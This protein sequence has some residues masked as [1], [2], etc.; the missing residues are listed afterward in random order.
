MSKTLGVFGALVAGYVGFSAYKAYASN[1]AGSAPASAD[2]SNLDY[3]SANTNP[4]NPLAASQLPFFSSSAATPASSLILISPLQ[5]NFN[6]LGSQDIGR[7]NESVPGFNYGPLQQLEA[8]NAFFDALDHNQAVIYFLA[9]LDPENWQTWEGSREGLSQYAYDPA[10]G[11]V[12]NSDLSG[13]GETFNEEVTLFD[14]LGIAFSILS[15]TN[16]IGFAVSIASSVIKMGMRSAKPGFTINGVGKPSMQPNAEDL[17]GYSGGAESPFA[18]N[19]DGGRGSSGVE[20][21]TTGDSGGPSSP[22]APPPAPVYNVFDAFSGKQVDSTTI[23]PFVTMTL[24]GINNVV[25]V[26]GNSFSDLFGPTSNPNS[27]AIQD[28]IQRSG[29]ITNYLTT[30]D[31]LDI[32]YAPGEV[33]GFTGD[34]STPNLDTPNGALAALRSQQLSDQALA[35]FNA[36]G[37]SSPQITPSPGSGAGNSAF[38]SSDGN[39]VVGVPTIRQ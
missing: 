10:I 13:L 39:V 27:F 11:A 7:T 32:R 34:I 3:L 1:K 2:G 4:I 8:R 30:N 24:N 6:L 38:V 28:A 12:A 29:A 18:F 16:P 36:S 22:P 19:I 14:I 17:L 26:V 35:A 20:I 21:G 31:V 5:T 37:D 25:G 33:L 23:N 15:A 9:L